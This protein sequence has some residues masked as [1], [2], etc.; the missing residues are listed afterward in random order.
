MNSYFSSCT[1]SSNSVMGVTED[2]ALT[3]VNAKLEF[4]EIDEDTVLCHLSN[5]MNLNLR[6]A[7]GL[8]AFL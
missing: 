3:S 5:S 4:S 6:K 2:P 7:T 1:G 8:M